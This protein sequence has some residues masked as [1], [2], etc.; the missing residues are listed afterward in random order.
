MR[1]PRRRHVLA[2]T[3]IATG[4]AVFA[5]PSDPASEDEAPPAAT[6]QVADPSTVA[7][8]VP[9]WTPGPPTLVVTPFENHV[10]NGKS[11]EWI[12]AEAPFE[13]AEKAENVLGLE[14][15]LPPLY[16]P[17]QRIPP[18]PD[19]V[20]ELAKQV[21]A[22][23][24][25]TGWFDRVG[26]NLRIAVLVWKADK[27][28]AKVV[29][30]AQ[31]M[32]P[33]AQYHRILGEASGEAWSEAGIRVDEERAARLT[34]A[35]SNDV[36]P[37]FMMGRGLGHFTGALAAMDAFRA[38][39][40]GSATTVPTPGSGS[41]S[42]GPD[43]ESAKHDLERAVF[44][45]PKLFEAQRLLGELYMATAAGDPK[46]I[47]KATGKFN[48]AA[49][50]APDDV[51]SLRAAAFAMARAGKHEVA[52]ELFRRLVT[53]RPWDLD[54]RYELGSAL[55]HGGD[56]PAAERQL[57]QV[58]KHEP[59]HLQAR[60]VLVLIHASR[61]DTPRLIRELEAIEVHAPLDLEIKSDLATA[62]GAMGEWPKAIKA[63]ELIAVQ[64]P[65]D[66]AL[67]VRIGDAHRR[68]GSLDTALGWYQR[69]GRVAPDSS[70]PGYSTAQALYDAGR[71]AEASKAYTSLL[72]Y[73]AD[74]GAAVHAIG[75][76]AYQSNITGEAAWNLRE[77]VKSSPRV[78]LSRRALVAAELLRKDATAAL[79]QVD[80]ALV[81][82]PTDGPLHYL[83]GIAH[84]LAGDE[85][86]AREHLGLAMQF[87]GGH[88]AAS[89]ALATLSSGGKPTV[90]FK[91]ELV[92]PWSD[93]EGL[94]LMLD[95]YEQATTAMAELRVKYQ[96]DVLELLG[97]VGQGPL[98]R[99]KAGSVRTCPV[100]QIA[101]TWH[102]AQQELVQYQRLGVDLEVAYRFLARH[103]DAALTA[104]L[105]P[106]SRVAV[107]SAKKRFRT[108][109]ADMGELRAEWT[110]G[111]AQEL[112]AAGCNDK[113]LAAAFAD[114]QRY[115][116]IREDKPEVLPVRQAPRAK[117][118]T[119]FFVDN[120]RCADHVEVWIDGSHIGQVAPGRRSALVADGG[121]RTLCLLLPGGAQCGDRGTVRQVYL[122]DGWS[123]TLY[124]PK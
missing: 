105:L 107:A 50:L 95:R 104:G 65:Q 62:Y 18:D 41:G 124:C 27:S 56:G 69:A 72:R 10:V 28:L 81:G 6:A 51:P 99:V 86:S 64:R 45:D 54:A 106:G 60:R 29:G 115:R 30:E 117:P 49:D 14:A 94:Q 108:A 12:I 88:P 92:R 8:S 110:R 4:S 61:N 15:Q 70:L 5:Q 25:V 71:L 48:Y 67:L 102:R 101:P 83:A 63:L 53:K 93:G 11:L 39:T 84:V 75:V 34:R 118:R 23:F 44:L 97:A 46:L 79:A 43:L 38:L 35:L 2:I 52:L 96:K 91:P 3:L 40:M 37:V 114:P 42:I 109:L 120:S 112:R 80:A 87:S 26:E 103:D 73:A 31:R 74:R 47:A 100:G 85:A 123:T 32:G 58:T 82:W 13:I 57:E 22:A 77:A 55:W 121:E 111:V 19:T 119:T 78:L 113:L 33:P 76:I 9:D 116:V 24:V 16:V 1:S 90:D 36:Y 122:H 59:D 68:H 20:N 21:G 17:G 98:A 66:L 89:A 7:A